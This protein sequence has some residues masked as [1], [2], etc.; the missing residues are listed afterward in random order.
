LAGIEF[1]DFNGV[2][3]VTLK[4]RRMWADEFSDVPIWVR[5]HGTSEL[6]LREDEALNYSRCQQQ[7]FAMER[8]AL[9]HAD[10]WM[11]PSS[12]VAAWY[13]EFYECPEAAVVV[14][15]PPFAQ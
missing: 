1:P 4:W 12:A 6:W 2:G 8:Y 10:G 13:R 14:D 3:F 5:L 7:L 9:R 15:T 11:A